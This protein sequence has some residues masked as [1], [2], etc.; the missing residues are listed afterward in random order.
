MAIIRYPIVCSKWMSSTEAVI[1]EHPACLSAEFRQTI[2]ETIINFIGY[3]NDSL[4]KEV[5]LREAVVFLFVCFKYSG[6]NCPEL[7]SDQ[8]S[9]LWSPSTSAAVPHSAPHGGWRDMAARSDSSST[10]WGFGTLPHSPGWGR[11]T[12]IYFQVSSFSYA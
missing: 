3:E 11:G 10:R 5:K 8:T 9:R 12:Q 2:T 1:Q 4:H 7:F 6:Q